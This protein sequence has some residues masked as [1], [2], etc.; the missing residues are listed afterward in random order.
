[1]RSLRLQLAVFWAL[2]IAVYL[3]LGVV[4]LGLYRLSP[5]MQ[6][7]VGRARV[8]QACGQIAQRYAQSAP[9]GAALRLDL[10]RVLL[11]L[12]LTEAPYVEGGLWATDGG[13]LA[14]AYPTY[15]GAGV[16]TDVPPAERPLLEQLAS[17]AV[18]TGHTQIQQVRGSRELL[19]VAAC[20]LNVGGAAAWTMTR[21]QLGAV[22]AEGGLR[23]GVAALVAA[24][25]FSGLWLGLL[26]YRGQA[27]L[28]RLELALAAAPADAMPV[29]PRTGLEE[30]DRIV[31][32][33]NGFAGRFEEARA[34]ARDA[35]AQRSRDMRLAA[36]GRMSSA[37]AHEIRN[38]IA[39]MRLKAENA[40]AGDPP[41]QG[42]A[43]QTIVGQID[44]LD[45]VVQSLLALVQPLELKPQPVDLPAWLDERLAAAMPGAAAR[46]VRLVRA[47]GA[48]ACAVFDPMHLARAIDN[49]LDNAVRHARSPG[50]QV[51]LAVHADAARGQL[52]IT[53]SD[54]GEGVPEALRSRL[55]E[56]FGTGRADGTGLGLA[57]S[58]EVAFAH[59]G[60]LR[61]EAGAPGARFILEM[62]WQ[63]C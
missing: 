26:L 2:L 7:K 46:Q 51:R 53:V 58:R 55:F 56:P 50:G 20:P 23:A 6:M 41:A 33:Y 60:E 18:D 28:R 35:Q 44:R 36:L 37:V 13:M 10:G 30:L 59:G 24:I 48:P 45:A 29:L 43:L 62:P 42:R 57:L 54:D 11:Q 38:P 31:A 9:P 19:I 39:A 8:E 17:Q 47:E 14:Y 49:L 34:A 4:M 16:K 40:L 63:T 15:E 27:R 22:A 3:L 21:T 61:H 1:M 25:V 5:A 32:S 12:V 52:A